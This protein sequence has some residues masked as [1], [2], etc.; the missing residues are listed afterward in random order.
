MSE[1]SRFS[2][3]CCDANIVVRLITRSD[4]GASSDLWSRWRNERRRIV[5][6]LLLR[7]EVANAFHR[8]QHAGQLSNE[9]TTSFLLTAHA[10]PIDYRTDESVHQ[11][12]VAFARQFNRPAAYDAH[13][14]AVAEAL[15]AEFWTTDER[16][17]N[18]VHH[19]L[20]WVNLVTIAT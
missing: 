18:A 16:L 11:R 15:S 14:L 9:T 6:P 8:L 13:Y 20:T 19:E 7:Y 5:A 4:S 3:V 2:P 17:F 10:L 1:M 12:A